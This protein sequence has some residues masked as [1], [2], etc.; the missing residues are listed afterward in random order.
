LNTVLVA[1]LIVG[2]IGALI[3]VFIAIASAVFRVEVDERVEIIYN[4]LPH[5][6]CGACGTPGCMAM[7][8]ELVAGNIS[9]NKCKPSKP[10]A[11]SLINQKLTELEIQIKE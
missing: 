9:V 3:G 10:D 7:A 6:N 5:F 2:F 8:A 11:K 1:F 4:M